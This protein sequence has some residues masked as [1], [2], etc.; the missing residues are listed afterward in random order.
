M[1]LCTLSLAV[2]KVLPGVLLPTFTP[3]AVLNSLSNLWPRESM[4]HL[5]YTARKI[6]VLLQLVLDLSG[7]TGNQMEYK[8]CLVYM[9]A[10]AMSQVGALTSVYLCEDSE[11][12]WSLDIC[13]SF[14]ATR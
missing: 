5:R 4:I 7:T 8:M 1:D 6:I 13:A 10:Q 2:I 12:H 3:V 9:V 14:L 11:Y